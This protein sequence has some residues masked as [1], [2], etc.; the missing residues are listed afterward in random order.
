MWRRFVQVIL[1]QSLC[2]LAQEHI[3]KISVVKVNFISDVQVLWI[4]SFCSKNND[5]ILSPTTGI[6]TKNDFAK[7]YKKCFATLALAELAI[8]YLS[9]TRFHTC[10]IFLQK[11]SL[12][13]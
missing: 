8:S 4:L 1:L 10:R 2:Q 12:L 7:H 6:V 11:I 13:F 3:S 5:V 9:Q